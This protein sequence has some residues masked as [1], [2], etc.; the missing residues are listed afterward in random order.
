[1]PTFELFLLASSYPYYSNQAHRTPRS[2]HTASRRRRG[3]KLESQTI[4]YF[5][6]M[7]LITAKQ[8]I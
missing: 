8:N 3:K 2:M 1:M 7:T 4:Q 6:C 5:S